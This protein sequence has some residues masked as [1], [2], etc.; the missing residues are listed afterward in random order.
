MFSDIADKLLRQKS[1]PD[2]APLD[3]IQSINDQTPEERELVAYVRDKI[4]SCRQA[5][6]RIALEG[7]YLT[8]VAYLMGFDGVYYDA[9]YRQFKNSDP[10][11]RATRNRFKVNKILPNVQN[12]LARLTQSPPRFDVRPNSNSSEDKDCARLGIKIIEDVFDKQRFDEKRQDLLMTAMQGGHAYLQIQWDPTLGAPLLDPDTDEIIGYEGDIRLEVL[13][14]LEVFPDPL[15]KNMD[16]AEWVIKAKVRKLDYF[17]Q[18]YPDRGH[19][20][21]EETAWLISTM[22]DLKSNAITSVGVAGSSTQD[23][24][25]NA[26]IEIILEEKRSIKHPNGRMICIASGVLLEDKDLPVGEI[27]IVKFDDIMIG[28]RYNAEAVITHLRPVQDQYNITRTKCADWLRQT[29]AGKYMVAKGAGLQ[30]EALNDA[31]EV[32]QYNPVPNA[33]PPQAMTIPQIPNYVYKDLETLDGEFNE[34]SGINEISKGVLPSAGMPAAGMAFLQEQDQTRI[35]VQTTRNEIGYAR[36]GKLIL[37]YVGEYYQMPRMLKTAGDGLEYTVK[38]FMGA[39]LKDN[40]DVIVI[41]GSTIPSSKVLRRQDIMTAFSSGLMGNPQDPKLR[42]KVLK[43]MEYGDIA[44][45]WKGQALDEQQFRKSIDCIENGKIPV[46][47]EFDNHEFLLLEMNEW[48]KSDKYD[49]M[50]KPCRGIFEYV[51][52]WHLQALTNLQNP[53]MAQQQQMSELMMRNFAQLSQPNIQSQ[54]A[55]PP[56]GPGGPGAP[57]PP[58]IGGRTMGGPADASGAPTMEPMATAPVPNATPPIR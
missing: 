5:N 44:E 50:S 4:D 47:R 53:G 40:F 42:A 28:S 19:A 31:T 1:K 54:I 3:E 6:T 17:R 55:P 37:R 8:N 32:V 20:V 12:R 46:M 13:N 33:P 34:I 21:K 22:Y 14:C 23:Q 26:A 11:R 36:A 15:A 41:E 10:K 24:M 16:E 39:D 57:P 27:D 2:G 56:P 18:R 58:Q 51:F 25:K 9:T 49:E 35:G 29:L 7:I 52:E 38:E 30:Q 45:V 43:Y 48:R